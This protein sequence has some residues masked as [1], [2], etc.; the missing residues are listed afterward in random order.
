MYDHTKK[1]FF[2]MIKSL[3]K[4]GNCSALVIKR[5]ILSVPGAAAKSSFEFATDENSLILTPM[6]DVARRSRFQ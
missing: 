5:P 4:H 1:G 3:V 2:T 6:R